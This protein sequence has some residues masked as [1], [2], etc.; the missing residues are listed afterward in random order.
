VGPKLRLRELILVAALGGCGVLP[1]D[2]PEV[3]A[4]SP[5]RDAEALTH[6]FVVKDHVL[7][8]GASISEHEANGFHQRT[9]DISATGYATPWQG[10]CEDAG[11]QKRQ[12]ELAD[13]LAELEVPG[14][15]RAR[16]TKFGLPAEVL[17][18][19]LICNDRRRPPPLIVYVSGER[20]MTCFGGACYLLERY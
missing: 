20:A 13:V 12:R 8:N 16:A 18:Y 2:K 5:D 10:T 4:P 9:L 1:P 7:A 19:R 17:E 6:T 15:G 3:K 11:R 14:R